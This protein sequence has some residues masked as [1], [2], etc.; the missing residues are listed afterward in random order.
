MTGVKICGLFRECDID[1]VNEAAPDY[2]GFIIDFPQ[3][4][5]SIDAERARL[6]RQRL[7]PGVRPVGVFVNQPLETA[8]AAAVRIGLDVIQLHGGEDDGYIAALRKRTGLP[9]WKAFQVRTAD[10]LR[11]A[12]SS[13]ADEIV[14]D[15]G[16]GTGSVFDWS[17]LTGFRRP[18][19]LAGGLKPETIPQALRLFAP[20]LIDISSGVETGKVKDREKILAAVRAVREYQR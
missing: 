19:I 1:Y 5:R 8:A 15:N 10:G 20:K 12:A 18:F 6:L 11:A 2:V 9:I 14:L 3:S 13:A 17:L 16:Y 7:K 4:H